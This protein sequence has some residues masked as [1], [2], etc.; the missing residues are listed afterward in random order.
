MPLFENTLRQML[1]MYPRGASSEQIIWRLKSAGLRVDASQLL[2]GLTG[3]SKSGEI[4]RDPRGRWCLSQFT[5][6]AGSASPEPEALLGSAANVHP[7]DSDRLIALRAQTKPTVPTETPTTAG[8][9]DSDV[10]PAWSD[11]LGYYAATQRQDPR[12]QIEE[13][14]DRHTKSWQLFQ[15]LG[16]WWENAEVRFGAAS[17]PESFREALV[18]RNIE[19]AALGWPISVVKTPSGWTYI[20]ALIIPT[21]WRFEQD[22][23]IFSPDG[24]PPSINPAWVR[25]IRRC[26]TWQEQA[27][28]DALMPDGEDVDLASIGE[29]MKHA[30]A[31]LG[32]GALRP[33][34]LSGELAANG[35]VLRNSAAIFLPEDRTFTKGAAED[36]EAL[37]R[38]PETLLAG[39]ALGALLADCAP[40]DMPFLEP[41][42]LLTTRNLTDTQTAAAEASLKGPVTV[43]QGPPGTGKSEVI[44]A[45]MVSALISGRTVLLAAKNHQ[46][47]DEVE[48]RLRELIPSAPILV[49]AR[50]ADGERDVSFLDALADLALERPI[51][52]ELAVDVLPL[53]D[54]GRTLERTRA[55]ARETE[56]RKIELSELT[57]RLE[58]LREKLRLPQ[59]PLQLSFWRRLISSILWKFRKPVGIELPETASLFQVER[60]LQQLQETLN[61][62]ED[63]TTQTREF[64]HIFAQMQSALPKWAEHIVRPDDT[65]WLF[66]AQR[67]KELEFQQIKAARR[68]PPDDAR[69]I[70]RRRPIWAISTLSTPARI[71]LVSALFDYVII[72][73]ASQCDIASA[74]P[75]FARAKAAVIVGDPMQLR[76]VPSL[77]TL[78]EHALMDAAR[79]PMQGRSHFAQSIN[80]LFDFAQRRPTAKRMFLADQFRSAPEIVDYLNKDFYNGRLIGRRDNDDFATPRDYKPGLAW[81]DVTGQ[82][83]RRDGGNVNLQEAEKIAA[84]VQR[85]L[86]SGFQGDIGVISPFNAQVGAIQLAVQRL[87]ISLDQAKIRIAT[88]DKFQGGEADVILFSLVLAPSAP[89]SAWTFLQ[90]ERRRLNVAVSRARAVCIVVGDLAYARSCR[91]PHIEFL[92]QRA[93]MP[94]SP[95]KPQA[96]ESSWE[97]RLATAMQERGL[98]PISQYSVG[99][100]YLDFALDPEGKKIDVE[101]DG[102]RWHTDASGNRKVADRL[103]DMELQGRG[104]KVIRFWVHELAEDM[105]RCLDQ[106]ER[107]LAE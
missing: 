99:T 102:R 36:L 69:A 79:F 105:E 107:I 20:P 28:L 27:L 75:L 41:P 48:R 59:K 96:F 47:I 92:A 35:P 98:S 21:S 82:V 64:A 76:F 18:R 23:I 94:W 97:R 65:E 88:V 8:N 22:Q 78:T 2:L 16:R 31:T 53:L 71:P 103:R 13:F 34:D 1:S 6:P 4:I 54:V 73:E 104:W 52:E 72:D 55:S 81:E 61:Q 42:P 7:V 10:L 101:V 60:R 56:K 51:N 77:G 70:V 46:A 19:T 17:A 100:R 44:L 24:S 87:G 25:E 3:L 86:G 32:A 67:L 106:I 9:D 50:D 66:F 93:S 85:L 84:L 37:R 11:L 40:K 45:L 49:R 39:T 89:T 63:E 12:G 15:T 90:K 57:E 30:L 14:A 74:L 91:I 43:I 5:A 33:A 95:P 58:A 38:W 83:V 29:R 80:S 26:S 62:A 68:M